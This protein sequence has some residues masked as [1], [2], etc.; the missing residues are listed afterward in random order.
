MPKSEFVDAGLPRFH[1][2]V[3]LPMHGIV[4]AVMPSG[5]DDGPRLEGQNVDAV[6][7]A[8]QDRH[9]RE[10][11]APGRLVVAAGAP[12]PRKKSY[13]ALSGKPDYCPGVSQITNYRPALFQEA[14][15]SEAARE[16]L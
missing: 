16:E 12:N 14:R 2:C 8:L 1:E 11:T 15:T 13:P 6:E 7:N 5:P 4:D 9:G 3:W 10:L